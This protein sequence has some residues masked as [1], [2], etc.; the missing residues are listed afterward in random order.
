M[1]YQPNYK[2]SLHDMVSHYALHEMSDPRCSNNELSISR[3]FYQVP[4]KYTPLMCLPPR[5][6]PLL[7][8]SFQRLHMYNRILK[9]Y[10]IL[11]HSAPEMWGIEIP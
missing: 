6:F 4:C 1:L 5:L 10:G 11:G 8:L 9:A 3:I 7:L 2:F